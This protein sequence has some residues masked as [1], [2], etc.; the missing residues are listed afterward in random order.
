MSASDIF[1]V[2]RSGNIALRTCRECARFEILPELVNQEGGALGSGSIIYYDTV[3]LECV[4]RKGVS[5]MHM[6]GEVNVKQLYF[7]CQVE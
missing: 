3:R 1:Q 2:K 7:T 5:E 4:I 6:Y